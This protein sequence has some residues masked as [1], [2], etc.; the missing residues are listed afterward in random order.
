[1][2][3]IENAV[4]WFEHFTRN[5]FG[6]KVITITEPKMNKTGNPFYGRVR[7]ITEYVNVAIGRNYYNAMAARLERSG[8]DVDVDA[9]PQE[10]PRGKHHWGEGEIFLQS[11][12]DDSVFYLRLTMNG[13]TKKNV[14]YLLDGK[15][16]TEEQI[17]EFKPWLP[18]VST[19]AK[20]SALGLSDKEQVIV[21]DVLLCN[22]IEVRQGDRVLK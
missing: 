19:S 10:K 21:N 12:K 3:K 17:A 15:V 6:V 22:V 1:M 4:A 14:T 9:I 2:L 20:Q 16:A 5:T 7:K 18:K 13:N 8:L 11:D